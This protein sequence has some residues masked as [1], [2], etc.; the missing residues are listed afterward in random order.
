M[1]LYS[2]LNSPGQN[3]GVGSLSLVREIFPTQ[4]LIPG[5]LHYRWILYQL[6]HQ[7]SSRIL[8]WIAHPFSRGSSQPRNRTQVSCI[9]GRFFTSWATR[10][11]TQNIIILGMWFWNQILSTMYFHTNEHRFIYLLVVLWYSSACR[12][13]ELGSP[14]WMCSASNF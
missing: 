12:E 1:G 8:E 7:G 6:S 2:P 5:L 13:Y 9:A 3:T 4:G 10:E 11:W 14:L